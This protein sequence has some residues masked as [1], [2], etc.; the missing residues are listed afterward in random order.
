M[1]AITKSNYIPKAILVTGGCG[2][3]GSNFIDY[4]F[5]NKNNSLVINLDNLTYAGNL[6]N[7]KNHLEKDNHIFV[8]GD[9]CD[10]QKVSEIIEKYS[11]D[12]IVNFAAESHVDRSITN[13]NIFFETNVGGTL[14]LLNLSLKF[15]IKRFLQ[16]S[17]DEV[18][19]SLDNEGLFTEDSQIKPNSPYSASKASADHFVTSY[20]KTHGLDTIIT[21]CS[22]NYGPF[23]FPEKFIPLLINNAINNKQLPIYGSGKNIRDWIHVKDHCEG[24]YSALCHG[25]SGDV[26]NFGGNTEMQNIDLANKIL[27]LLEKPNSLIS[28]VED[29]KGHD[30]RYAIDI[31]KSK[32][33]LHWHP[34]INFDVGLENT[35]A[36]YLSN[37]QWLN[38]VTSGEYLKYYE[39][40]YGD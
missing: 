39:K 2:F 20:N 13:S 19:G 17:T 34:K 31:S 40:H 6:D 21:R 3:I 36:W 4:L 32:S 30:Y 23:Q 26:Y 27:D 10:F 9:I 35:I 5:S 37:A 18:Y 14:T 11:I 22:N 12:S 16:V 25:N 8:K 33:H 29:R 15:G 28:H 1:N 38:S 7:L 24:I